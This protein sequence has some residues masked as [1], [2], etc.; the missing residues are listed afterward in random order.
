MYTDIFAVQ[1]SLD[2]SMKK[3]TA[4]IKRL[5]TAVNAA[6]QAQ[7]LQEIRALSLHKYLS[8]IISACYE[9]L[10]KLKTPGEI[11]A[12]VEI[13]SALHQR[14]G[15]TEFTGY[16][17]WYIGRGLATPDKSHLKTLAPEVREREE[18]ERL[19]RQRVLLRV[20]TE[21]WLVGVLR[22]LDDVARP[23]EASKAKDNGKLVEGST[24]TKS[25]AD[26]ADAE[27]FPLEVLKDM[28]GHDREHVNL[29]LVVIFVKAF[30]WDILGA[31]PSSA[32]G[33]KTV[34]EDGTTTADKN[35]EA[36]GAEDEE[37]DP[38][39]ISSD[40]QQRFRNILTRYFED[41][42]TH[43]L[44]DQKHILSQGR[45][46]AEA[47]VKSGEVFEDRQSNYE[48]QMKSQERLVTNA[49]ILADALGVEMPDLK[50]KDSS[51]NTG[52]GAIGLVKAGEY[53]RGQSDGAGIWEDE[54]ERRFYENLIDLKDRVPGILLEEV[55][56]K[57]TDGDEQVGK[58]IEAKPEAIEKEAPDA[59][60]DTKPA[61]GEDQST[62]IANKSVG[63]QVDA[64]LAR[65]PEL[66]TKDAVD[67]TAMDFCFLNSK[68]SRN[69]LI[70]A[71]QEI[72]KGRSDLLPLYSRLIATLGKY[73][74]D[75]S[76]GLVSYLD[77]E[78]RSLQRRKSKDFLGQVRTQ[79]VR[80]LAELT[81]FGVVPEHVIF[82]C[83]KVSLDDFSR[84]NIEII[85]NLL[86]NCGR[87][88]LRNPETSPRMH[89]F[90]ETL[91]RKKGAQVIGQQ[92]RML[93]ENAVY[94]VNPP[95]RAAIEQKERT[96]VELF[97]RKIM[98]QD[99]TR[100]TLDK[101]IK[102]VRKMHWEEEE[103]VNLLHKV[104]AKPG[105]IKYSNI[106]LLAV[107]LGTIHRFH[108]DFAISV[109]DDLLESITFGLELNDFKFNQRRISEVK[110]L[111]E[112]YI[113][114]LV[115]SPLIFDTLYKL[116]NYGWEGGYARPGGYNPLDLSDDYFRIRL[117]CNLLETC[118][119]YYDKGAAKKKL[120]FFLTYLQYYVCIK[121]ALPMDVEFIVQDAFN[122]VR[123]QWKIVTNLEEASRVFAEAVKQNYQTA[124]ADKPVE[125]DEDDM[126]A[127]DDDLDGAE[128]E[129][130]VL[131]D[132]EGDKSS[133]DEDED[134][135]DDEP[136]KQTSSDEEEEQIVVTRQEDER[137][138]EADAEFDREL[139][140]L[141]SESA[142]SRKHDR[143]PVFDVP[144]P[145]R[146]ARE[147]PVSADDVGSEV[148]V[149]VAPAPS[150]TMKFSLLSKRGNRTQ[151]RSIDLPS[152]STF[153]VAMRNKQ[154]ADTEERQRIK[155]L[156]LNYNEARDDADDTTGDSPFH[157]TLSP[158]T[159]RIRTETFQGLDKTPNPYA[160]PRLDKAGANR[161]NQRARKLQLS[162]VNWYDSQP[163][164][165]Q[166]RPE[167]GAT[168]ASMHTPLSV[169]TS[170]R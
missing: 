26:N 68:A 10:C 82:H 44:R 64:L 21:L 121:E 107:M 7:F 31:K 115:D 163:S 8:E 155:S 159:N 157:Y 168:S 61:D 114:R 78:F 87:Y 40:L 128:D 142:E 165:R 139:A 1:A 134:S 16:I 149:P 5:R 23:E 55:K 54:E 145:M 53:L 52:D 51:A 97:L 113:Y 92:E 33:R 102:Q 57:K 77:D 24:K 90:L 91:Q 32:E 69:R 85:C 29:P 151:T 154:Q 72:P 126:S 4:F 9:G 38:P 75:V 45:K 164:P 50:E 15:P 138:P 143:K 81:K 94:Y 131:P 93:I 88:L 63:A 96:P 162:D 140:K 170:K 42:K 123:P 25:R 98:Y 6:A 35:G 108:Q 43:L 28:L 58:K 41:V 125:P 141:M 137:D 112:L 120:D 14:F 66:A 3:N 56:K 22:S 119:M 156:V 136:M 124:S 130:V 12:G 150:Q 60:N 62:A 158:N 110:Y 34:N 48:K 80:Y 74:A 132:G 117:V 135:D 71:V 84:M 70:K 129:D 109:I 89:S 153:A 144:L 73:M 127:S 18:K 13:V 79:N 118:G 103:V 148:P 39:I 152:D 95:E 30:A 104:F 36:S 111:G 76:Q 37:Q 161:S 99:L 47:Y 17:G 86:E 11:A 27:P 19:A 65:L 46:N 49:Q 169:F 166:S 67:Q 100:R 147:A 101:T 133:G 20:A 167:P 146:R 106:H 59:I 116:L 2:S 83:L 122:L 105:K 160:Q